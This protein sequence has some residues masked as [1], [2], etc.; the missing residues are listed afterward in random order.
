MGPEK[1]GLEGSK[2]VKDHILSATV[3]TK[4]RVVWEGL[5]EGIFH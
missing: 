1:G 3:L 4:Y 5:N 2:S